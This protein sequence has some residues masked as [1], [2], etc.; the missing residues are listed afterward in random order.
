M[1]IP[2]AIDLAWGPPDLVRTTLADGLWVQLCLVDWHLL[3]ESWGYWDR[4]GARR[5]F[6]HLWSIAVE[7]QFHLLRPLVLLV[8]ARYGR[9]AANWV[10]VVAARSFSSGLAAMT[11]W[12][13]GASSA[14]SKQG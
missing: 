13:C 9:R 11:A 4:L 5:V 7:E 1:S 2:A 10:A 14:R 6:G 8:V 12:R 3:A